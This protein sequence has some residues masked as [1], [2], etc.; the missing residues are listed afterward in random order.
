MFIKDEVI[1]T[2]HVRQSSKGR[3]HPYKRRKTV[4][5]FI[6]DACEKEFVRDKGSIDPKRLTN[7]YHHV[8]PT[9]DPKRFAQKKGV[10][11]RRKLNLPAD[12]LI[13]ID[14]L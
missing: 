10:E 9:C 7:H 6:C 1:I 14:E 11:K 4:C 5:R 12:G 2:E 3:Y 13:T 8:C